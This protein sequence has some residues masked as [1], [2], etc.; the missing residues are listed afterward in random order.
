[1]GIHQP[2]AGA[3]AWSSDLDQRSSAVRRTRLIFAMQGADL[4]FKQ[5][6]ALGETGQSYGLLCFQE[7]SGGSSKC[8][9]FSSSPF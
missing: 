9:V 5:S 4:S 1:M 8:S 7:G 6:N 3:A 2:L